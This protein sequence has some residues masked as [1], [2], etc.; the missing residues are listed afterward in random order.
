MY[1]KISKSDAKEGKIIRNF[2]WSFFFNIEIRLRISISSI[3]HPTKQIKVHRLLFSLLKDAIPLTSL[4]IIIRL[5]GKVCSPASYSLPS[6]LLHFTDSCTHLTTTFLNPVIFLALILLDWGEVLP[7]IAPKTFLRREEA[8]FHYAPGLLKQSIIL[9]KTILLIDYNGIE[10]KKWCSSLFLSTIG[11]PFRAMDLPV[12]TR[13]PGLTSSF[14][15]CS[16]I[17][18]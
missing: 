3:F 4:K 2:Y 1:L 12:R 7:R 8:K 16:L 17:W 6:I 13:L 9:I 10:S 18:F 14:L 5:L 15:G 11:A